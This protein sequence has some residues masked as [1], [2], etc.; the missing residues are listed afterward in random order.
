MIARCLT[1]PRY[2]ESLIVKQRDPAILLELRRMRLFGAFI[3]KVQHNHLWDNFPATRKLMQQFGIE[4]DLF[5][6]YRMENLNHRPHRIHRD[7]KITRFVRFL[8][9]TL[10]RSRYRRFSLL[11]DV[12]RHERNIWELSSEKCSSVS[13]SENKE[14]NTSLHRDLAAMNWPTFREL[15]PSFRGHFRLEQFGHDPLRTIATLRATTSSLNRGRRSS[16]TLGYWKLTDSHP[17]VLK[18]DAYQGAILSKINGTRRIREIIGRVRT[19]VLRKAAPLQFRGF[20]EQA[21]AAGLISL[22]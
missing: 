20:F 1:E 19:G 7:A 11:A 22:S 3:S 15:I 9:R 8:D 2:L 21:K 10:T 17:S 12:F 18:L 4:F 14:G 16:F 6:A 5:L 13:A